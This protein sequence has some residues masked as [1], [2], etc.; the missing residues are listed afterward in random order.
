M[1]YRWAEFG[2]ASGEIV[3]NFRLLRWPQPWFL[4]WCLGVGIASKECGTAR[5]DKRC[6]A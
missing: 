4:F 5:N 2:R 1:S 3:S 6:R